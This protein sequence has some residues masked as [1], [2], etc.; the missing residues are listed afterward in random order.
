[1]ENFKRK[2]KILF[3]TNSR[4]GLNIETTLPISKI[5]LINSCK[6]TYL[7][8]N[9]SYFDNILSNRFID[10]N[11]SM[12]VVYLEELLFGNIF[13][14]FFKNKKIKNLKLYYKFL[15]IIKYISLFLYKHKI[16]K[17]IND[18]D[19]IFSPNITNKGDDLFERSFY[20]FSRS[21]KA[22]FVGYPIVIW[23]HF[24]Q[25]RIF[26]FDYFL[27][28]SRNELYEIKSKGIHHNP[29]FL[30]CPFFDN[31]NCSINQ[32]IS[33]DKNILF[34]MVNLNNHIYV[35]DIINEVLQF[36]KE[37][38]DLKFNVTV[39]LHPKDDSNYFLPL[40]S[41]NNF[42][43]SNESL[44]ELSLS[45]KIAITLLSVSILVPVSLGLK[46]FLF[47]P[48]KLLKN[49]SGKDFEKSVYFKDNLFKETWIS[50]YVQQINSIKEFMLIENLNFTEN[51][52][53]DFDNEFTPLN[54]A[55]KIYQYF[56]PSNS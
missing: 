44:H 36:T 10:S 19:L 23:P 37:L 54:S 18:S 5:F 8:T 55:E 25:K 28:N 31:K 34:L 13:L 30:G 15:F 29:I 49:L 56:N 22:T 17:L 24:Y 43:I 21:S 7:A 16:S 52:R 11:G 51:N 39:K 20:E 45:N 12:K 6:I 32:I 1:M 48:D 46:C 3:Y 50:N 40:L 14:F 27:T 33:R 26:P 42:K 9:I 41:Y 38:L 4:V 35:N 53:I 2:E 47:L